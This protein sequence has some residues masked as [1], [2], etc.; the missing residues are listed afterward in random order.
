MYIEAK[1]QISMLHRMASH[2]RAL[3][4]RDTHGALMSLLGNIGLDSMSHDKPGGNKAYVKPALH[5]EI[6]STQIQELGTRNNEA[7]EL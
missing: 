4:T 1:D 7:W 5:L 6:K 2:E 3:H